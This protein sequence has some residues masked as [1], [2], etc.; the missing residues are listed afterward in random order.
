MPGF[1][2]SDTDYDGFITDWQLGGTAFMGV[3]RTTPEDARFV[4]AVY[5]WSPP[6]SRSRAQASK[7]GVDY[8]ALMTIPRWRSGH[9]NRQAASAA[10]CT[11][12][13][14]PDTAIPLSE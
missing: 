4:V 3:L 12:T 2:G 8:A 6:W 9:L 13:L 11:E 10:F 7:E 14:A 5:Q 1:S